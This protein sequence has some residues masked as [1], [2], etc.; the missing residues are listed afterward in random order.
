MIIQKNT[1]EP[2]EDK[3]IRIMVGR[4]PSNTRID[5]YVH[6][7]RSVN[8]GPTV[9]LMGGMHGGENLGTANRCECF[10]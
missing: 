3:V 1:I 4:L 2:G 6:V 10:A 5:M 8:E 7:F 9:L